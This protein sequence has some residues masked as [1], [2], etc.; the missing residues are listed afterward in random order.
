MEDLIHDF[1]GSTPTGPVTRVSAQSEPTRPWTFETR[2]KGKGRQEANSLPA[3]SSH[4]AEEAEGSL[5]I[6]LR[7]Q[8][9]RPIQ[10]EELRTT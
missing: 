1:E 6:A 4:S 7:K 5:Q 9:V 2:P 3:H 8:L 10:L